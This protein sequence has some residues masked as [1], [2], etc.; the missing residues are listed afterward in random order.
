MENQSTA[1]PSETTPIDSAPI[2]Q[3]SVPIQTNTSLVV[4]IL[5]TV[6]VSAIVFGFGGYYFGKMGSDSQ[7]IN[8]EPIVITQPP[9]PSTLA[10]TPTSSPVVSQG[11]DYSEWSSYTNQGA[12][13]EIKYPNGWRVVPY[14]IGEGYG[15]KEVGE[16]VL[17]AINFYEKSKYTLDQVAAEFGKQFSDR[18]QTKQDITINGLSAVKYIT[19]TPSIPDWYYETIVIERGSSYIVIS[20]GAI[21]NENLQKMKGVSAG[22]TFEKFYQSFRFV[23]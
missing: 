17:W 13:Y 5:L 3:Q 21:N 22:T 15:P 8:S 4:P 10:A 6:L 2:I 18:K 9:T 16:D 23:N 7:K 19:T 14:N 20:N 1:N 12:L 11:S